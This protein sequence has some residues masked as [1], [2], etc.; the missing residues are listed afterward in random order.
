MENQ[1]A[2]QQPQAVIN[3]QPAVPAKPPKKKSGAGKKVLLLLLVLIFVVGAAFAGYTYASNQIKKDT[4]VKVSELKGQID[5]LK[6]TATAASDSNSENNQSYLEIM[7]FGIKVPTT[8]PYTDL[9]YTIKTSTTGGG[10]QYAEVSSAS[11]KDIGTC[12]DY[13]GSIGSI[14]K[15]KRSGD[16]KYANEVEVTVGDTKYTWSPIQNICTSDEKL[17]LA[18]RNSITDNFPDTIVTNQ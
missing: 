14:I 17:E 3:N 18:Y 10:A 1:Q 16:P 11:L 8:S 15:N 5:A 12:S 7:Q 2:P 4:E 9:S 13:S 6:E